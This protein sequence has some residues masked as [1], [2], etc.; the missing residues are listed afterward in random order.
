MRVPSDIYTGLPYALHQNGYNTFAF[1]TGNPQYDNMNSFFYDNNIERVYSLYDYPSSAAVNNFGVP[2]DYMFSFGL[3]QL[4]QRADTTQRPFF[5]LFLTVSNHTPFVIPDAYRAKGGDEQQQIIAY[6]DDAL[7]TFMKQ[8]QQTAWGGNTVFVL[9]GD[10]GNP[11]STPYDYNLQYNTIPCFFVGNDIADTTLTAPVLQQDIA[12][13][14]L[15]LLGLPYTENTMGINALQHS[16]DYAYFVN[17]D[18]LGCTDGEWLYSYSIN[19]QQEFLY[20]LGEEGAKDYS[21]EEPQRI[22]RMRCY[23]VQHQL[24]NLLSVQNQWINPCE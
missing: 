22:E 12:P 20:R 19:T 23:A 4:A 17:N 15:G 14:L 9:V 1:V 16:R 13:T 7:R 24:I 10:H 5:A 21:V 8:A 2:D 11:T 3:Q 6:A 18:H